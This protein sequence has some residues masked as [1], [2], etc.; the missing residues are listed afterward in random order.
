MKNA[1]VGGEKM[2][3]TWK[4]FE[5]TGKYFSTGKVGKVIEIWWQDKIINFFASPAKF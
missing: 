5:I 1:Q 2:T 4:V 3:V